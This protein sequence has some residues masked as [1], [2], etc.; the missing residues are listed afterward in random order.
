MWMPPWESH[1][2][3][4]YEPQ[5]LQGT[6]RGRGGMSDTQPVYRNP[7]CWYLKR[8]IRSP[9]SANANLAQA[10]ART[11]APAGGHCAHVDVVGDSERRRL[12][13]TPS[14]DSG[15]PHLP[16]PTTGMGMHEPSW[17]QS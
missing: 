3:M 7:R 4:L 14:Y 10:S 9:L 12:C 2:L 15:I 1:E 13:G 16:S 17:L 8:R 6:G 5:Q 11:T